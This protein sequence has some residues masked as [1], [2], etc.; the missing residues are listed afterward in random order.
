MKTF[1]STFT[2]GHLE[3]F[4]DSFFFEQL[5]A[6]SAGADHVIQSSTQPQL[7]L[8]KRTIAQFYV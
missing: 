1:L 6:E 7:S 3:Q 8:T 5:H 4:W 2:Y